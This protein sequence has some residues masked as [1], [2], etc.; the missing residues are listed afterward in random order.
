MTPILGFGI[1]PLYSLGFVHQYPSVF[2]TIKHNRAMLVHLVT[3][4]TTFCLILIIF[5]VGRQNRICIFDPESKKFAKFLTKWYRKSGELT[6]FCTDLDWI[7]VDS[8]VFEALV[9]KASKNELHLSLRVVG[10]KAERLKSAGAKLYKIPPSIVSPH[11]FSILKRDSS[12]RI[13]CRNKSIES[14][15]AG[16]ERVEFI[17]TSSTNEP[18]LVAL[19]RDL[20][21]NCNSQS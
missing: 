14:E 7:K 16:A 18:Y 6:M 11:R 12:E 10:D 21:L 5:I 19:A 3:A 13:I 4:A 2:M 8:S 9:S 20:L 1:M 17:N 15:G